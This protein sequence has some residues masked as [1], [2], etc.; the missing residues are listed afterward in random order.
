MGFNPALAD[1]SPL[2]LLQHCCAGSCG[3]RL[4]PACCAAALLAPLVCSGGDWV[5]ETWC[6]KALARM[7][8]TFSRR[9]GTGSQLRSRQICSS[10]RLALRNRFALLNLGFIPGHHTD[11]F[12][13]P[14]LYCLITDKAFHKHRASSWNSFLHLTRPLTRRARVS[15]CASSADTAPGA[16]HRQTTTCQL[17]SETGAQERWRVRSRAS[18]GKL[19]SKHLHEVL[20]GARK[21]AEGEL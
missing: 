19:T 18:A 13:C 10:T 4:S 6:V 9:G 20:V 16:V 11:R 7:S 12:E 21:E 17:R 14:Q 1:S 3:S 8:S 5:W 15:R 2:F